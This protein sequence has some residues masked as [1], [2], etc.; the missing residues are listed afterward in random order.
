VLIQPIKLD[1]STFPS[2][3]SQQATEVTESQ[4]VHSQ[5][6]RHCGLNIYL[7]ASASLPIPR[8]SAFDTPGS[9]C[10][11]SVT[12]RRAASSTRRHNQANNTTITSN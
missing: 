11:V 2:L 5:L 7:H 1:V 9:L 8:S 6:Y 12:S 10:F 3:T 4:D